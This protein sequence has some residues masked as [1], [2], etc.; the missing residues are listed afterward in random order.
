MRAR[1]KERAL[2]SLFSLLIFAEARDA[3]PR[4]R[5]EIRRRRGAARY[6]VALV[7]MPPLPLRHACDAVDVFDVTARELRGGG[8]RR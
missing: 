4:R 7:M 6:A 8:A 2:F 1:H 3:A 5:H